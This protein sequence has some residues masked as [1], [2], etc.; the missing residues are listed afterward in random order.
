M[1]FV[2]GDV[3]YEDHVNNPDYASEE[4]L[5][6]EHILDERMAGTQR[7]LLP[8]WKGF[9]LDP[10]G[11]QPAS[12]FNN[13]VALKV[14]S[15]DNDTVAGCYWFRLSFTRCSPIHTGIGLHSTG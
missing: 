5:K 4:E 15:M 1:C 6:V 9:E 13:N 8:K 7:E 10:N 2:D 3:L 14:H 11:W 12:N